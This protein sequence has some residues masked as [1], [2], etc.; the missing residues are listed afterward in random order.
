MFL[1]NQS[2]QVWKNSMNNRELFIKWYAW[3]TKYKDCDPSVWMTNYLNKRYQHNDEERIWLCWLYGNTYYL[4]TSWVL[5]NEFPDY[6]L[7][8]VDRI[9]RWNNENYKRLR[10][11]TDTKYNK[12]HLPSMF[13]SYKRFFKDNPQR[14]VIESLYG[15]NESQNFDNIWNAV[16]KHF[17]K[18]GRYTTWFYMQHLKHTAGIKINPTSLMLNDYSGSRSHRNG[19]CYALSK[20]D[21]IDTKLSNKEYEYLEAQSSDIL[22]ESKSRYPD[23]S[24]E[25]DNFTMETVLCSF[26]KIFRESSSRYLGYYLDRQSEEIQRV[27]S[28]NWNGIDWNV[29]WQARKETLD[30]RLDK[31]TGIDKNRFGEYIRSGSL[32][33]LDWMFGDLNNKNNV[34]LEKF[35][36]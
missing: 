1:C 33:R 21:W 30:K 27:S 13:E 28:D 31:R 14:D 4:P 10:Y 7:A 11:Q 6:E 20:K 22:I 29:L 35:F 36:A 9:T 17:H 16:N 2:Y 15:D 12:G 19:L 24:S 3:S 23:L 26:K 32:S 18:F 34:G 8:T 5:K 25:F